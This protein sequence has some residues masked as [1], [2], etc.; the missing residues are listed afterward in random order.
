MIAASSPGGGEGVNLGP[1]AVTHVFTDL[2][3]NPLDF[4]FI[5]TDLKNKAAGIARTR[6]GAPVI[7]RNP[8]TNDAAKSHFRSITSDMGL[9]ADQK[10]NKGNFLEAE[11]SLVDY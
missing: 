1:I 3:P 10:R 7:S 6:S 5:L 2:D 11:D 8:P 4:R 9:P